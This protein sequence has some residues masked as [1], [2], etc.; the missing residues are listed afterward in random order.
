VQISV[1]PWRWWWQGK[2]LAE[3]AR[4]QEREPVE[5]AVDIACGRPGAGIFHAQNEA[6]V[7]AFTRREWVA[8]AS[9]GMAIV[10]FVG[11]F[12]HPRAYGTFPRKLRRYALDEQVVSLA[13]A[14]RSMTELPAEIFGLEDRGRLAPGAFADVVVFD[15]KTI[16]DVAT[17]ERSGRHSEG[18]EWLLVNGVVSIEAGELTGQRGGRGLRNP[19]RQPGS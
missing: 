18:V 14:L 16:R 15:P 6:D 3:L 19:R 5:L 12:I 7:R 10:D 4:D 17:Y 13:F 2:T 1:Y 8:T 9:D 11:R